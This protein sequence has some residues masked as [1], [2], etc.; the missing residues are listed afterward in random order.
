MTACSS[1]RLSGT[2]MSIDSWAGKKSAKPPGASLDVP[3]WMPAAIG[4]WVKW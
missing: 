2:G 3:V 4:P 1:V